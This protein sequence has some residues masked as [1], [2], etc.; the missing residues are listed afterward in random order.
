[1]L[2]DLLVYSRI[3]SEKHQ[4]ETLNLNTIIKQIITEHSLKNNQINNITTSTFPII[5]GIRSLW[6]R[7]L[8]SI[9]DNSLRFQPA[10]QQAQVIINIQFF[11]NYWSL[12]IEDNGIGVKE[13]DYKK[14]TKI[15]SRLHSE[16][17]YP[18][19]GIGLAYCQQIVNLHNGSIIFSK[20]T[21]GGLCVN[22][23]F[24]NKLLV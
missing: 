1:M 4:Y 17:E 24:S 7:L 15:F 9:I 13:K 11:D 2:D 16:K 10:Q 19:N 22:C 21:L 23:S 3:L 18:G 8:Y 6:Y 5:H 20:S 12:I 14:I